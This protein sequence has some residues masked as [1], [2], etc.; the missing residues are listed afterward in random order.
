MPSIN[1]DQRILYE[2]RTH[3]NLA[4]GCAVCN[5][6][7]DRGISVHASASSTIQ[8]SLII[9]IRQPGSGIIV[10]LSKQG[11]LSQKVIRRIWKLYHET[12]ESQGRVHLRNN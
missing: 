5:E 10:S 6:M 8:I 2:L 9:R 7:L 12:P 1:R 4:S 3:G 11:S